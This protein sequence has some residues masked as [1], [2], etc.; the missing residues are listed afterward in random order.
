MQ[1]LSF[2]RVLLNKIDILLLDES[3]SNLDKES[4]ILIF[5]L[6]KD[7]K[8][9]VINSTHNMDDFLYDHH[10]EINLKENIRSFTFVK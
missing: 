10:L 2:I 4:K 9:T 8:I 6:L 7:E 1:K 5:N 3:T